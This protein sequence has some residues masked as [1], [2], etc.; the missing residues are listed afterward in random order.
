MSQSL[1]PQIDLFINY[2]RLDKGL[3]KATLEA[4]S[5]DIH[6]F[7]SFLEKKKLSFDKIKPLHLLDYFAYLQSLGLKV[8]SR[9]RLQVSLRQFYRFLFQEGLLTENPIDKVDMPKLGRKLPE[10]LSI[11][12]M[13]SLLAAPDIS[14]T[15]GLRDRAMLE[16]IYATGLRVSE[17]VQLKLNQLHLTEGYLLA[18]G[19][20]AKERLVPMGRSSVEWIR[21]YLEQARNNL[22]GGKNLPHLFISQKRTPITRQQFWLLLKKYAQQVGIRKHLSPHTLRHSFA[23]HLLEGG[24]DLRAVQALLGHADIST[25]QIYTHIDTARL[26][27]V[28]KLHPRG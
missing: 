21:K 13:E 26:K 10:W 14:K 5:R 3:S 17:L 6:R 28:V 25:T 27:E 23:T 2:L 8:R 18:F 22:L 19:K 11:A 24:A 20:G 7:V 4:Y 12:E 9:T 16:L 15:K 1:D